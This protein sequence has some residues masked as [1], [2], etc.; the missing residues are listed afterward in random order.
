MV[1]IARPADRLQQLHHSREEGSFYYF[2]RPLGTLWAGILI[3]F[4]AVM[5]THEYDLSKAVWTASLRWPAWASSS[6]LAF[7]AIN[8][9]E[10]VLH[11]CQRAHPR[12]ALPDVEAGPVRASEVKPRQEHICGIAD[13]PHLPDGRTCR[14]SAGEVCRT[15][16]RASSWSPKTKPS[17]STST[18]RPSSLPSSTRERRSVV[19]QS[20]RPGAERDG[21]GRRQQGDAQRPAHVH[22]LHAP[23]ASPDGQLQRQR[24]PRAVPDHLSP[25]AFASTT[26]RPEVEGCRLPSHS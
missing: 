5:T 26:N 16:L 2:F 25:A 4:G 21:R 15:S 24:R 13:A 6:F 14:S 3:V 8:L 23:T 18:R 19:L 20:L 11:V 10:Q 12:A 17:P 9:S 1:L 7:L 22:V